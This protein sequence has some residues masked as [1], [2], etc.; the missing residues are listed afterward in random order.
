[1]KLLIID[2]EPGIVLALY[3]ALGGT[4]IVDSALS[5]QAGLRKIHANRYDIILL[6]L[7][8]R[9]MPGLEVCQR[10]RGSGITTPILVLSG[11]DATE[12]KVMLL[13]S[14]AD[15]Y[16][17]KPFQRQELEARLRVLT[18]QHHSTDNSP[19][20]LATGD[21]VLD[22]ITHKVTRAGIPITLRPKEFI[23]LECLMKNAGKL[24]T[25]ETLATHAWEGDYHAVHNTVHVHITH[26]RQKIDKPFDSPLIRTI[27]GF[28]YKID[29]SKLVTQQQNKE[30]ED[31]QSTRSSSK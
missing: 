20:T 9:D 28:G 10:I 4:Y 13:D 19:S 31:E 27:H 22:T 12:S 26:L 3:N 21:L 7:H 6:D 11:E 2:D 17:T 18:R 25:R 15:D 24:V 8:L 14:G 1:M 23:L 5:G 30:D 16:L 29:A